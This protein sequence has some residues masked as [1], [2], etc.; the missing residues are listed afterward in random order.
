M[1]TI[2]SDLTSRKLCITCKSYGHLLCRAAAFT[3]FYLCYH[4][5]QALIM[6]L[7]PMDIEQAYQP[8]PHHSLPA[9]K[10]VS[11]AKCS[12]LFTFEI[13][14]KAARDSIRRSHTEGL[15]DAQRLLRHCIVTDG[16]GD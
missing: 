3:A 14:C 9:L 12:M 11:A 16:Q 1:N 13:A 10:A 7:R 15:R 2:H 5:V 4:T 6:A 8:I